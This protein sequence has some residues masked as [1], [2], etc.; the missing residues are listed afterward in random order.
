MASYFVRKLARGAELADTDRA[1]MLH[2]SQ[3]TQRF[4]ARRDI[5]VEG[6]EPRWLP[7]ILEGWA[8][9]YSML[10][11]GNRQMISLL[12]PGDL[13]EPF[14]MLSQFGGHTLSALTP[15][16]VASVSTEALRAAAQTSRAIER[17]LWWDLLFTTAVEREHIVSLGQRSA[18]E[19]LGHLFC[20]LH[21]RLLTAGLIDGN[22]FELP[23]I[24][25]DLGDLLG[26]STVHVNRSLQELRKSGLIALKKRLLTIPH[27]ERLR[28]FS[29]FDQSHFP[30]GELPSR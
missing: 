25:A 11:N 13:C 1:L 3:S 2:M 27:L 18:S 4:N 14:G 6:H 24:Q 16:V 5:V 29:M 9:R 15:V 17:A 12:L 28:E 23:L 21:L 7:L 10:Q 19:S 22:Q 26:L 20:E 30:L 8:C